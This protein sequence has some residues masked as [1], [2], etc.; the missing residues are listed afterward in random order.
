MYNGRV[1]IDVHQHLWTVP[2]VEALAERDQ[3]PF[4]RRDGDHCV[5]YV[6][7]E[8]PSLLDLAGEAPDRRRELLARDGVERALIAI[9]SPLGIEALPR[10]QACGLIDAHLAG[11]AAAGA[12]FGSWGPVPLDGLCAADVE[13][14]L[15]LGCAG[16]SLPA[17]ALAQPHALGSL[18][19]ALDRL[20]ELDAPLFVHP[21][22]GL[23]QRPADRSLSDPLWWPALTDYVAQMQAAWLAFATVVRRAH[24]RLRVVFAMLAGGAPLL[25]ERLE[26]RGGPPI[27]LADP[28]CYYETSSY[29]PAA[30]TA[31]AARVGRGQLLYG[32]DRP[33]IAPR[34]GATPEFV[35][36]NAGWLAGPLRAVVA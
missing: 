8:S 19:D 29:G 10:E 1:R 16:I 17:G 27:E 5:V 14:A 11:V 7:G 25:S 32:S 2:L 36:A 26:A 34:A 3:L 15:A 22:P 20:E 28:L 12:G 18:D 30:I 35:H 23:G 21:G 33:V 24:P 31:T 9:S 4:V 6:A 13:R